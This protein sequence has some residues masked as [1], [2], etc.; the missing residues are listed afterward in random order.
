MHL[1]KI[2][3]EWP[4]RCDRVQL[5]GLGPKEFSKNLAHG[6]QMCAPLCEHM[7]VCVHMCVYILVHVCLC[8]CVSS[9]QLK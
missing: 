2:V 1:S 4:D 5:M 3:N 7:Y 9:F 8:V 6:V